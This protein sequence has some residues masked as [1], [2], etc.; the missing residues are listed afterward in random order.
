MSICDSGMKNKVFGTKVTIE[1][2][3]EHK[4]IKLANFID[5][6]E[7]FNIVLPDLKSSTTKGLWWLGRK[8]L[9]R[10]HLGA[11]IL[12][13]LFNKKDREIELD[14]KDTP[15]YQLFCGMAVV[16]N[17]HAPDHTAI[18]DFRSRLAPETQR[19]FANHMAKA[20][21]KAGFADPGVCDLDSTIQEANITYPTDAKMFL[22]LA[23][24][25]KR[26][27][28]YVDNKITDF[29]QKMKIQ[30]FFVDLKKIKSVYKDYLFDRTGCESTKKAKLKDLFQ[31]VAGALCAANSTCKNLKRWGPPKLPWNIERTVSQILEVGMPYFDQLG[32]HLYFDV[33]HTSR[34]SLHAESVSCFNKGKPA[35]KYQFGRAYQLLRMK[36][37]FMVVLKCE[38]D[39]RME[40]KQAIEPTLEQH[41]ALFGD[42][43]LKSLSTDRN[44]YSNENEKKLIEAGVEEI[45]LARPARVKKAP[46]HEEA[47][48]EK[49]FNRRSGIEPLIGHMKQNGQ[50]GKSRMKSDRTTLSA[51]YASVLGFNL[52]QIIRYQKIRDKAA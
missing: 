5:W 28:N 29:F 6:E 26:I 38:D 8:L 49:L 34:Y 19:T 2:S 4:L 11:Y 1:V 32:K 12:Q 22:K 46:L 39:L 42:Q 21:A 25:S 14:I 30:S 24:L 27:S 16:E 45:G 41:R 50:L 10:M 51:G 37:N 7:L 47:M 17:W 23:I 3:S 52:R 20:A 13:V 40:D 18:E 9:V 35:K 15:V 44:Y 31:S 36:G 48:R 33:Q 43:V